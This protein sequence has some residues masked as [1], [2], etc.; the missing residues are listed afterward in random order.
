MF[1][2][3]GVGDMHGARTG[4][5][6]SGIGH[7]ADTRSGDQQIDI[8]QLRGG[9]EGGEGGVLDPTAVMFDE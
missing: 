6:R 5:L 2:M 4:N 3:R 1:E 8:A 7:R 9:G